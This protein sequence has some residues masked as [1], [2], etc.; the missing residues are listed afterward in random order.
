M[1]A[2]PISMVVIFFVAS[3]FFRSCEVD[4]PPAISITEPTD[5][6]RATVGDKIAISVQAED[7][8]GDIAEVRLYLNKSALDTLDFPFTCEIHT[9]KFR[10][11][12]YSI[13]AVA[14]DNE[15]LKSRDEVD[16]ILHPLGWNEKE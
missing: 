2:L 10:P 1:K 12:N 5:G 9:E 8:E 14:V 13:E 15:G 16:F 4:Q 7:E 3:F 11:G 6:F